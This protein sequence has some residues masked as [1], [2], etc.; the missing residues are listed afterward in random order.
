[1]ACVALPWVCD[2]YPRFYP[3]PAGWRRLDGVGDDGGCCCVCRG[4]LTAAGS[5]APVAH[6]GRYGGAA[7]RG[8]GVLAGGGVSR[9]VRRLHVLPDGARQA[10]LVAVTNLSWCR[11]IFF[12][13]V[14]HEDSLIQ[15]VFFCCIGGRGA[16]GWGCCYKY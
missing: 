13:C 3:L 7:S 9:D 2:F 4:G 8:A 15:T 12:V 5:H 6:V 10:E 14:W 11:D 16:G 1:M